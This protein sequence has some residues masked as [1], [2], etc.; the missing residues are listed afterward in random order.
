M[1]VLACNIA[2]RKGRQA[3]LP[4]REFQASQGSIVRACLKKVD[5]MT[6]RTLYSHL[7]QTGS[8]Y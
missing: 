7:T 5:Q 4:F 3:D 1:V 8:L 6:T 2:F